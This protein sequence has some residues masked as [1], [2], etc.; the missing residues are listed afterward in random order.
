M[1]EGGGTVNLPSPFA[2]VCSRGLLPNFYFTLFTINHT[3]V[4]QKKENN[5]Y[6][7]MVATQSKTRKQGCFQWYFCNYYQFIIES[8]CQCGQKLDLEKNILFV[9][10]RMRSY[11][12]YSELL[13]IRKRTQGNFSAIGDLLYIEFTN[14]LCQ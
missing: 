8:D 1:G 2:H 12:E 11:L 13:L 5:N 6:G 10:I 9:C 3:I 14:T 4:Q 7:I